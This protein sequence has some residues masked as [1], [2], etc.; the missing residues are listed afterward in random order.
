MADGDAP[1][2]GAPPLTGPGPEQ[3]GLL[4]LSVSI[5]PG[6]LRLVRFFP[7]LLNW[8]EQHLLLT[9]LARNHLPATG[10]SVPIPRPP[11]A[12]QQSSNRHDTLH[13][14]HGQGHCHISASAEQQCLERLRM[15]RMRF[16][17]H[18]EK[19]SP[20]VVQEWPVPIPPVSA[21][22]EKH[23]AAGREQSDSNSNLE[24]KGGA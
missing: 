4:S 8:Y 17:R 5:S 14:M 9:E 10:R 18:I 6:S 20:K 11:A 23:R 2:Q 24:L 12:V 16:H 13:E 22:T 19:L 15:P 3:Q 21:H 7:R 1:Q